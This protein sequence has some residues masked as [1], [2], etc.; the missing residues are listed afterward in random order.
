MERMVAEGMVKVREEAGKREEEEETGMLIEKLKV[1]Q[2]QAQCEKKGQWSEGNDGKIETGDGQLP[3][4]A[5]FLEQWKGKRVEGEI[6]LLFK[7]EG[8]LTRAVSFV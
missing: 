6:F 7:S 1:L 5:A 2:S 4:P 8:W 3:D